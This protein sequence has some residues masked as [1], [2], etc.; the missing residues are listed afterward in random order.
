LPLLYLEEISSGEMGAVLKV[1][2]G[3]NAVGLL[4]NTF[5][6]L[7]RDWAK[8]YDGWKDAV[9]DVKPIIYICADG[10]LLLLSRVLAE[11][12]HQ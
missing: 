8:E 7:K 2:L 11:H 3:P 12:P 1:L 5:L 4:A 9:S 10:I 6:P